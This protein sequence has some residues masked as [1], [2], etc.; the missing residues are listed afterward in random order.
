MI[1]VSEKE[2]NHSPRK[3]HGDSSNEVAKKLKKALEEKDRKLK[4]LDS[5]AESNL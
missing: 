4:D 1:T 5:K 2:I 3:H